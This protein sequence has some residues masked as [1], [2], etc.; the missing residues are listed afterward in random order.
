MV[1]VVEIRIAK[2]ARAKLRNP[3]KTEQKGETIALCG[4]MVAGYSFGSRARLLSN[5]FNSSPSARPPV[6]RAPVTARGCAETYGQL[7]AFET[8][9]SSHRDRWL[10]KLNA[11]HRTTRRSICY[12]C[13]LSLQSEL[14]LQLRVPLVTTKYYFHQNID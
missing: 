11:R 8:K 5:G 7:V 10:H 3:S 13:N 1:V 6:G 4:F 2:C 14:L 9:H 12:R